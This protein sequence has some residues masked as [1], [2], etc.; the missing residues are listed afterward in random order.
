MPDSDFLT[1]DWEQEIPSADQVQAFSTRIQLSWIS[2]EAEPYSSCLQLLRESHVNGGAHL[3]AFD[4]APD[5]IFHWFASRNRLTEHGLIDSILAHPLIRATL[6][7]LAIPE[8]NVNSGLDLVN[9]FGLD[10]KLAASLHYGGAYWSREGNGRAANQLAL[11]VCDAMFDRRFAEISVYE[12]YSAWTP[13]FFEV[14]WDSTTVILDRRLRRL[15]ILVI[16]D[17]D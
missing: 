8:S 11:E 14:A 4:I 15:W 5:P 12:S 6:P 16:T 3:V 2:V 17:T 1:P 7:D 10:G 13:W 9:S